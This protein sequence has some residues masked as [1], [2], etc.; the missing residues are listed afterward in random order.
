MQATS[1]RIIDHIFTTSHIPPP[2]P[3]NG[4]VTYFHIYRYFVCSKL[5][6]HTGCIIVIISSNLSFLHSNVY[7][8]QPLA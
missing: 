6:G 2:P 3:S 8:L 4:E 5:K 1:Q 7:R